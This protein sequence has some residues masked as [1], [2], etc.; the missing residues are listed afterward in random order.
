VSYTG[1]WEA[2]VYVILYKS[3]ILVILYIQADGTNITMKNTSEDKNEKTNTSIGSSSSLSSKNA[4]SSET[5]QNSDCGQEPGEVDINK[6]NKSKMKP[7][8]ATEQV[9]T[10][11]MSH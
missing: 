6:E 9:C 7:V 10:Y 2:L 11:S 8:S 1:S 5:T 3:V 4:S